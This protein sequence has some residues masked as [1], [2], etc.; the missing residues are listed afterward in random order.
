MQ[1]TNQKGFS[2]IELMLVVVIVGIIAAIGV[3]AYQKASRAAENSTTFATMR[4][5]SSSQVGCYSQ[6]SRFCRLDELNNQLG[7]SIGQWNSPNLIRGKFVFEMGGV[8]PSDADLKESYTIT[9]T[10]NVTG[11]DI[12]YKFEIDQSGQITQILPVN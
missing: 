11:D 9:A 3:P 10:R 6:R 1:D 2:L 8:T 4:T 7:G 5:M 12:I